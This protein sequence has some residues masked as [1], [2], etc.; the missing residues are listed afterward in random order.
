MT[1]NLPGITIPPALPY[2]IPMLP[3]AA[4][5]TGD[6]L[7]IISQGGNTYRATITQALAAAGSAP[8][9]L[10]YLLLSASGLTPNA[11]T[12]AYNNTQFSSVDAG[13]GLAYTLSLNYASVATPLADAA[14]AALGTS[15][16]P[17]HSDHQHP[18]N[19]TVDDP[20]PIAGTATAGSAATYARSDHRHGA[21]PAF[22]G[23]TAFVAGTLGGVPVPQA[24]DQDKF[25]AGNG[26]W[27]VAAGTGTVTSVAMTVP[28]ILSVA[29]SPITGAGTLAVTLA[30]QAANLVFAGPTGGAA[31]A[32]TFRA[33][34]AL[35]IPNISTDKLTSGT[36]GLSRGGT[37]A[38]TAQGARLSILP[39]VA[40]NALRALIVNAGET[41]FEYAAVGTG[42]V[43]SVGLAGTAA[44]ITVTGATPIT[45][46][47]SWTLSLPTALT[48]TGKTVTGGTYTSPTL[49]GTVTIGSGTGP[50]KV[51]TGV[52]SAAAIN[53]SGAE[54]TGNLPVTNLNSGTS[55]SASTYWRGDG[56]WAAV[57]SFTLAEAQA[58]A[59]SF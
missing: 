5:V 11:R 38:T 18:I 31:A 25:L 49:G 33:L 30:T 9:S 15:L 28:S 20:Y 12:F 58:Q 41:D 57:A 32:P 8:D 22:A 59:L 54:V 37:A 53:L 47:G 6:A 55:A 7:I 45:T 24:G 26:T 43:T 36:L 16:V 29:G 3:V 51:A 4:S 56:T 48:F 1:G 17:A 14:S 44:E 34:D 50:L 19:V 23:A 40:G 35:D 21:V 27:V 42:T 46:T 10:L 52:V 13:A 39:A 2:S